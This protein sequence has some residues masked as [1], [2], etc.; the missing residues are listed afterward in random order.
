MK[1]PYTKPNVFPMGDSTIAGAAIVVALTQ[2]R[3]K[4]RAAVRDL[5]MAFDH[6]TDGRNWTPAEVARV[7]EIRKMVA[8]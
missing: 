5:L 8:Q 6:T 4:L 7:S 3:E 1:K 2:E